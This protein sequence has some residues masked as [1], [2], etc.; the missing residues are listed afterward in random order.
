MTYFEP[1]LM[2]ILP[3][4]SAVARERER[5]LDQSPDKVILNPRIYTFEGLSRRIEFEIIPEA[6]RLSELAQ[7]MI[8]KELLDRDKYLNDW[9]GRPSGPGLRRQLLELMNDLKRAGL[10]PVDFIDL[11]THFETRK[12]FARLAELYKDYEKVIK[13][14]GLMDRAGMRQAVLKALE[15]KKQLLILSSVTNIAIRGFSYL[16]PYQVQLINALTYAVDQVDIE[17]ICPDWIFD[18]DMVQDAY[19]VN[20]FQE[21][22]ALA[23][24]LEALDKEGRGLKLYFKAPS[25]TESDSLRWITDHLF[26]PKIPQGEA[27]NPAGQV[28]VLAAPGRYAEIEFIGRRVSYLLDQGCAPE[29]IAVA[30]RDLGIY[31]QLIEDV[32]RRFD[33]P[34]Y[35][36]RGAPLA[37]QAPVRALLALLRLARSY[38]ERDLVLDILASP[39]LNLDLGITWSRIE[40]VSLKAGITDDRGSGGWNKNLERLSRISASDRA[41]IQTLQKGLVRLK[42]LLEPFKKSLTWAEFK[43]ETRRILT[44]LRVRDMIQEKTSDFLDRDAPSWEGLWTC[45]DD[46]ER[47]AEETGL[48]QMKH[49]PEEL[50]NGVLRA[51]EG[52]N[53]G[54]RASGESGVMVLNAYDLQ[55]LSF[56]YLFLG[57]LNEGEF[58]RPLIENSVLTDDERRGL[59]KAAQ[60]TVLKTS[61]SDYR[62]QELLFYESLITAK[63]YLCLSY[64]R[65]D[66]SGRVRLPSALLDDLLRLWKTGGINVEEPAPQVLPPLDDALSTEEL[67]NGLA[68]MILG[69]GEAAS[70]EPDLPRELLKGLLEQPQH[71]KR[72]ESLVHRAKIE[73][74]R[75][76]HLQSSYNAV[77]S[78]GALQPWL[79]SLK[80]FDGYPVLSPTFMEDYGRCPF[81]F[82]AQRVLKIELPEEA[83]DEVSPRDE[84]SVFHHIIFTFY[85]RCQKENRLPLTGASEEEKILLDAIGQ[86]L[87]EAES[88]F[89][90]GRR[91]LWEIKREAIIRLLKR[92]LTIEQQ[93]SEEFIPSYF[94]WTFGPDKTADP[95]SVPL[96]SGGRLF[97]MGRADQIDI[98][99][100]QCRVID[101]KVSG[102]KYRYTPLLRAAALGRSSFQAPVYQLAAAQAFNKPAQS[103]YYLLRSLDRL[104][105]TL[106]TDSD[107]FS[108][109]IT[110]RQ[111]MKDD[112]RENFFNQLEETWT[113]MVSGDFQA[114][115]E[116]GDCEYCPFRLGCR[117]ASGREES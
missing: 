23:K 4:A 87:D 36:R 106:P 46:L 43:Q 92:W 66:E 52:Q 45:L 17:L 24:R 27:P 109:D 12:T 103:T 8:I 67:I 117:S 33:L 49:S 115:S 48:S 80:E 7:D 62:R 53:V 6:Q 25:P 86:V 41:D 3:S 75:E 9:P 31:D 44:Q 108:A 77:I 96:L 85:S 50:Q 34:L 29:S 28:D 88:K 94:E 5:F 51:L 63:R 105:F 18:L 64:S 100:D 98:S 2:L 116:T 57:G 83:R 47:A 93:R 60:R 78:P 107:V 35:F 21:T 95:L 20:P 16:N 19:K 114:V 61:T 38:W 10:T 58:P 26:H 110:K 73:Q 111:Q 32:F 113:R 56:D 91:P 65:M 89:L 68:Y 99:P 11:G 37:I 1:Q 101:Y 14:R 69:K 40:E 13:K 81:N 70:S 102:R 30:F 22:L 112:Q 54:Q 97:F 42:K 79:R 39:Y 90:I 76:S 104:K 72:W 71:K 82:W 74:N 55:G 59:N 15:Q 84:G